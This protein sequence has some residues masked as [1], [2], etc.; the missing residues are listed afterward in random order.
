MNTETT[1]HLN[2]LTGLQSRQW[3]RNSRPSFDTG[4]DNQGSSPAIA[5]ET[6]PGKPRILLVDDE[7]TMREVTR[8]ILEKGGYEVTTAK[9]GVT[10]LLAFIAN[11]TFAAVIS[12]L[13]M[14]RADGRTF[15]TTLR[16]QFPHLS[17]PIICMTGNLDG[18]KETEQFMRQMRIN[19]VLHKPFSN[20]AL[21]ASLARELVQA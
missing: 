15:I 4:P 12:D 14:P 13:R 3:H 17:L 18:A 7:P 20:A 9:D 16:S 1:R 5:T 21:L 11:P 10:G 8:L 2:Q 19:T 6:N